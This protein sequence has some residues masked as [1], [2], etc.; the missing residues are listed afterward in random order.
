[1]SDN[2]RTFKVKLNN[3]E[4]E[5]AV[6]KPNQKV[7]QKAEQ[8]KSRAFREA[9]EAG[10]ILR[11]KIENVMQEQKLW[12]DTKQKRFEQLA[13]ALLEG[14]LKLAK[15][16]KAGLTKNQARELA[17][18][19]RRDRLEFKQLQVERNQLDLHTA[20]AQAE[21][22]YFNYLVSACTVYNEGEKEGQ[23]Y[24]KDYDSYLSLTRL[25]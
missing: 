15:G 3:K 12:D 20:E 2:K 4:I 6:L 21:N 1:M 19:M 25:P 5:M 18:Q 11:A 22:V 23:S 16:G 7:R 13:K 9:V 10:A 24:F 14:E 17:I 8:Y